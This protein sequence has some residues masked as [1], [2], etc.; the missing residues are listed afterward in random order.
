MLH[1]YQCPYE[2]GKLPKAHVHARA[3]R[4]VAK[5]FLSHVHQAMYEDYFGQPA[6]KPYVFEKCQGGHR[7]FIAPPNWPWTKGGRPLTELLV[8]EP[9]PV[10]EPND[11]SEFDASDEDD[12]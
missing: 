1:V 4:W 9:S 11:A 6:P 3:R 12:E 2:D 7:H 8:D 5:L 10:K